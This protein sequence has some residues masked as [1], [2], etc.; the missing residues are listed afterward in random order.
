LDDYIQIE[1]DGDFIKN[2]CKQG[3]EQNGFVVGVAAA[4]GSGAV[5]DVGGSGEEMKMEY[6]FKF[7]F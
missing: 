4:D 7:L 2:K 3:K 1:N 6:F 5:A